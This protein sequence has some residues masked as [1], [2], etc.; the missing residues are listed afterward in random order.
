MSELRFDGRVAVI[1]GAGRGLGRAYALVLAARGCKV[2]VNDNGSATRGDE[3]IANPA[4]EVVDEIVSAGAEAIA[5]T[6][7]VATPD[8]AA[9]IFDP[10][11]SAS[12]TSTM[13]CRSD[14]S[15]STGSCSMC[16]CA[17]RSVAI[18]A[19][20]CAASWPSRSKSSAR[21]A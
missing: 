1:S 9:A 19:A 3:V 20:D 12:Q 18:G 2:V 8:G 4:Q 21:L 16:P 13:A 11:G 14:A 15:S 6:A 7:T 10:A 5:C 17:F